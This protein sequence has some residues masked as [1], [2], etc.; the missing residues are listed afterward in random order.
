MDMCNIKYLLVQMSYLTACFSLV[1]YRVN[2]LTILLYS[3]H[4]KSDE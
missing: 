4:L 1:E 2:P 3:V